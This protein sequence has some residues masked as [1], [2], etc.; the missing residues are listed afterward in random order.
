MPELRDQEDLDRLTWRIIDEIKSGISFAAFIV[1]VAMA[2]TTFSVLLGSWII[3]DRA[4]SA[5]EDITASFEQKDAEA[6]RNLAEAYLTLHNAD[7]ISVID[8]MYESGTTSNVTEELERVRD[9]GEQP[10]ITYEIESFSEWLLAYGIAIY[11]AFMLIGMLIVFCS[12]LYSLHENDFGIR[13][14]YLVDLPWNKGWPYGLLALTLLVAW[15]FYA[16]SVVRVI[17]ARV[18]RRSQQANEENSSPE[19]GVVIDE[20]EAAPED[21]Q[22]GYYTMRRMQA[23]DYDLDEY[24]RPRAMSTADVIGSIKE[25]ESPVAARRTYVDMRTQKYEARLQSR[26]AEAESNLEDTQQQLRSYGESIKCLQ[27]QLSSQRHD[28]GVITQALEDRDRTGQSLKPEDVERE[29]DK[30]LNLPGVTSVGVVNDTI[31]LEVNAVVEYEGERYNGGTWRLWFSAD[32]FNLHSK[33][34]RSG[35]R[36][37]WL[38]ANNG[39][40]GEYPDYRMPHDDSFC[41]GSRASDIEQYIGKGM[42]FEAIQLAINSMN[43]V[44]RDDI[45]KI[46]MAL[47]K[48][49]S[50]DDTNA[51]TEEEQD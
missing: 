23:Y 15:P 47:K 11:A 29:F 24:V 25:L 27:R 31:V 10:V 35:V 13:E 38:M 17:I 42:Y 16:V 4:S 30:I 26:K 5:A 33:E 20:A 21:D 28:I 7:M 14:H 9:T 45:S 51:T 39:R 6:K 44:N 49:K 40:R 19:A 36:K 37:K 12:Y 18:K 8:D 48:L 3:D 41:F 1:I 34:M 22:G 46:P 50:S 2:I 43:T 32:G